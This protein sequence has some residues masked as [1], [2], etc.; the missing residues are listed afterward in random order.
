MIPKTMTP[1]PRLHFILM[2]RSALDNCGDLL[3]RLWER[4]RSRSHREIEIVF[5]NGGDSVEEVV[6]E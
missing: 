6:L 2:R 3:A 5:M 1:T 4:N